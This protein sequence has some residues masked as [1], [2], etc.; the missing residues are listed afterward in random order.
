MIM[1]VVRP[2]SDLSAMSPLIEVY[3]TGLFYNIWW[4]T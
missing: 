3:V 2:G 4:I 1:F